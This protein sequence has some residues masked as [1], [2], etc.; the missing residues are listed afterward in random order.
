MRYLRFMKRVFFSPRTLTAIIIG[1][2]LS[3]TRIAHHVAS[4]NGTW[5]Y[6]AIPEELRRTLLPASQSFTASSC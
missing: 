2:F 6:L 5:R 3:P 1:S 4:H